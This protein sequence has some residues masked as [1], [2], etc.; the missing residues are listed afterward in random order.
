MRQILIIL[1]SAVIFLSSCKSKSGETVSPVIAPVTEA[2]FASG[3]I[4]SSGQFTLT[5]LNDGYITDVPVEEGDTVTAGQLIF[6][7]DNAAAAVQQQAATENLVIAN[8]NAASNSA[9]LQQLQEQLNTALEKQSTDKVQLERMQRLYATNSVAKIDLDNAALTYKSSD[10]NVSAIQQNITATKLTLEQSVINSRSQQQTAAINSGYYSLK[11]PGN[12]TVYTLLKR[13]GDLV[14][15]GDAL[16]ILGNSKTLVISLSVDEASIAKIQ[17]G[18]KVLVE[19]NTEKGKTYYAS[20]TKIYP[21]FDTQSQAYKVD[22]GFEGNNPPLING[23][24]LQANIIVA[25]KDK[26]L[27]IPRSCL[28]ADGK[29]L[30]KN[31]KKT[32]T[33]SIQTGI[34]STDWVEVIKGV[35]ISDK[36]IKTY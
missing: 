5:A 25:K 17:L 32:D 18:Q 12:Y 14:R 11:S 24:L 35:T 26:A 31:K 3:H 10:N 30:V 22:A 4:E 20:V 13:K 28:S 9:I 15:K 27:L 33:I 1:T 16:A 21:L 2:V 34:V 23:T 36:L 19:L 8:K 7:Q 6:K 29:V